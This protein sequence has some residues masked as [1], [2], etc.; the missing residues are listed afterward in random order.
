LSAVN[1]HSAGKISVD[2]LMICCN[3]SYSVL[4]I[5]PILHKILTLLPYVF[6]FTSFTWM[7]I[8]WRYAR[9][10]V[11]SSSASTVLT[12]APE[13]LK[14]LALHHRIQKPELI[15][16]HVTAIV[17]SLWSRREVCWEPI[18]WHRTENSYELRGH[19]MV[20][21]T[22]F[23]TSSRTFL[24]TPHRVLAMLASQW[25]VRVQILFLVSLHALSP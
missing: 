12:Y 2:P 6:L 20:M 21:I 17:L 19:N 10:A 4:P 24:R 13:A 23:L 5:F 25:I 8:S 3:L 15:S 7:R 22:S 11:H 9:L 16:F 1:K 18:S 14:M